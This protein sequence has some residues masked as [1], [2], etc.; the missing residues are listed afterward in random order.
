MFRLPLFARRLPICLPGP[1]RRERPTE[2]QRKPCKQSLSKPFSCKPPLSAT[3]I[4]M[5]ATREMFTVNFLALQYPRGRRIQGKSTVVRDDPAAPLCSYIATIRLSPTR[6]HCQRL[7][8][9]RMR[10]AMVGT[11]ATARISQYPSNWPPL[12]RHRSFRIAGAAQIVHRIPD[13]FNLPNA[14]Y[15]MPPADLTAPARAAAMVPCRVRTICVEIPIFGG[16]KT[17]ASARLG[18]FES[19]TQS[20]QGSE[21]IEDCAIM[22]TQKTHH[23]SIC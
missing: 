7:G 23:C 20:P 14:T 2:K 21:T 10:D 8:K 9:T 5:G 6:A 19:H 1:M 12:C 4:E 18:R 13:C 3:G 15:R 16:G 11:Y 22:Q 17:K